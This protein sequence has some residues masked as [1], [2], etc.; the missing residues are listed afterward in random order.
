MRVRVRVRVH[1]RVLLL[2]R[3]PGGALSPAQER[4]RPKSSVSSAG[5]GDG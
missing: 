3:L 5:T 2:P 4:L 1:V